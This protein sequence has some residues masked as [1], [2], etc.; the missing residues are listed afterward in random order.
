MKRRELL[1]KSFIYA[2]LLAPI[3]SFSKVHKASNMDIKLI[4]TFQIKEDRLLSFM[5]IIKEVKK[6]LPKVDGCK[7]VEIFQSN[8]NNQTITFIETWV[9]IEKHKKHIKLVI[10]SGDWKYISSHLISEPKSQYYHE[11]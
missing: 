4:I 10:D 3:Q 1:K 9:N 2:L 7:G 6:S 8:D 11:I 5:K